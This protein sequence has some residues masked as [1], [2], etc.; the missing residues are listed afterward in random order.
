MATSRTGSLEFIDDA[1]ADKSTR[2][3]PEV[4]QPILS[5]HIPP[6]ALELSGRC[7]TVQLQ[8]DLKHTAERFFWGKEVELYAVA[9]SV[10]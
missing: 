3:N 2:I 6:V 10:I 5:P 1:T 8:N 4:F 7:F 9:K